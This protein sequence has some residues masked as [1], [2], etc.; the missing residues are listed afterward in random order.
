MIPAGSLDASSPG[1]VA[2]T[3]PL[4]SRLLR[5]ALTGRIAVGR[6]MISVGPVPGSGKKVPLKVP[7]LFYLGCTHIVCVRTDN[8]EGGALDML[9][10]ALPAWGME[11]VILQVT[12]EDA[13]GHV[14][15]DI[16]ANHAAMLAARDH[17][18]LAE[19]QVRIHVCAI[20]G[21]RALAMAAVAAL[22]CRPLLSVT[23][24][25]DVARAASPEKLDAADLAALIA[26][27]PVL[28]RVAALAHPAVPL[29]PSRRPWRA[30]GLSRV[31]SVV[32]ALEQ[33]EGKFILI[34]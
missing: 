33:H 23:E 21:A 11:M 28:A 12:A 9:A 27:A 16:A 29:P 14:V 24:A 1:L 5:I 25:L 3:R 18:R 17:V 8:A 32:E 34:V 15:A 13:A 31:P 10:E 4:R 30:E 2:R 20:G 6:G 19:R 26:C 22:A 7:H